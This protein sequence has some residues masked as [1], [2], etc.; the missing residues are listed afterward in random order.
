MMTHSVLTSWI[1]DLKP[2][3]MIN[4]SDQN[5]LTESVT[6]VIMTWDLNGR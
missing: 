5:Y 4:R 1:M 6:V 3:S 2:E